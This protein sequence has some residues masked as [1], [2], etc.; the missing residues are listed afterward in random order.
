[1]RCSAYGKPR[2]VVAGLAVAVATAACGGVTGSPVAGSRPSPFTD[3]PTTQTLD[4]EAWSPDKIAR[5]EILSRGSNEHTAMG[6][7]RRL[8]PAWLR[9]RGQKSFTDP[10]ADYPVVYVDAIR[11]G[12]LSTLYQIPS[13]EILSLQFFGTADATTRWGTGH[14]SG[15]INIVTGR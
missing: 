3:G 6:L 13:S 11:R 1:M 15:V 10:S 4:D 8:R 12:G 14:P 2:L 9:A 5:A 7:V